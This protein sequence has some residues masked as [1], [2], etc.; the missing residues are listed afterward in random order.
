VDA[1]QPP[2][3]D[4]DQRH[5]QEEAELGTDTAGTLERQSELSMLDRIEAEL[6]DVERALR[7]LD[8]GTYGTCEACGRSI[9]DS[10]LEASPQKRFCPEHQ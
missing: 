4:A 7:R 1:D 5:D 3:Q 9:E 10:L 8:E 2:V 6:A